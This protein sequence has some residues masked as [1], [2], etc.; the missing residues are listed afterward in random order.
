[1]DSTSP[2]QTTTTT[3]T[4]TTTTSNSAMTNRLTTKN[5]PG[6]N[7][8]AM[9]QTVR[10]WRKST[11]AKKPCQ[12]PSAPSEHTGVKPFWPT[13]IFPTS[14]TPLS[15][16]LR[17]IHTAK[18]ATGTTPCASYST[19]TRPSEPPTKQSR[20]TR[21]K[22][23]NA[24]KMKQHAKDHLSIA[25]PVASQNPPLLL[26]P[27]K[28][29]QCLQITGPVNTSAIVQSKRP[30]L[31]DQDPPSVL[32]ERPQNPPV[33]AGFKPARG[34]A[35][36]TTGR[37]SKS[38]KLSDAKDPPR[39]R[40]VKIFVG[41]PDEDPRQCRDPGDFQSAIDSIRSAGVF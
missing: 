3:S 32:P 15:K 18:V 17:T 6:N 24:T 8:G 4:K 9:E 35:R 13:P 38:H 21:S 20:N 30:T 28:T 10:P 1:M 31:K 36:P 39:K 37:E 27:K 11:A 40:P 23:P 25:R 33:G 22:R 7:S 41:P 5:T 16:T 29:T 34:L 12:P 14:T 2:P 19:T 26:P